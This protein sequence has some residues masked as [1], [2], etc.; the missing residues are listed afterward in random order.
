MIKLNAKGKRESIDT[1]WTQHRG[2]A[3]VISEGDEYV[4]VK[5]NDGHEANLLKE[6]IEVVE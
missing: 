6:D 2:E 3:R 5:W 4:H 1:P